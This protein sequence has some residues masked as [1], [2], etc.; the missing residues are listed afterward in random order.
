MD[1]HAQLDYA[2]T[3]AGNYLASFAYPWQALAGLKE[4]LYALG[5]TLGG[6]YRLEKPG[7]WVHE[8]ACVSPTASIA[9][10]CI[11]GAGTQVRQ[12]A[13]LRGGVLVGENC[14]VGNSTEL[15]N[16]ILFD[17]VQVPHFNYVGDSILGYCSHLGAG[18]IT[19]NVRLDKRNVAV[20]AEEIIQTGLRKFGA[21]LGDRAQ[22]GCNSVLDPGTVLGKNTFVSPLALVHG[23]VGE[24][25]FVKRDG[26]VVVGK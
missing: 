22:V 11:L 3:L 7:V 14:V 10:P 4:F 21:V 26:S 12:G 17:G 24:G 8:S 15:K 20:R 18:A 16:C 9:A 13:F 2:H 19:S 6:E 23:V 5:G 1:Y 25:S